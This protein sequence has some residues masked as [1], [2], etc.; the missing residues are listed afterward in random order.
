MR[1]RRLG[2]LIVAAV[3]IPAWAHASVI[4]DSLL[5]DRL[6]GSWAER[7][8]CSR[9]GLTFR[10]DGTFTVTGD[11]ADADFS[12]TF[13]VKDGRLAGE[14]GDR[15]MPVLQVVFDDNGSLWLGRDLLTAARHRP[16][17]AAG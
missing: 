17:A 10:E 9:G 11:Y 15:I 4:T 6:V 5:R 1:R 16:P 8:D 3:A 2:V 14:A 7:G 12:G 13:D